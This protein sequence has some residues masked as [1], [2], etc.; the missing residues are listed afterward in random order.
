MEITWHKNICFKVKGE[1][2]TVLVGPHAEGENEAADLV[3]T[4]LAE[5]PQIEGAVNTFNWPG[6]YESKEVPVNAFQAYTSPRNEDGKSEGDDVVIFRFVVDGITVCHLGEL[7]HTLTSELVDKIGDVD[8]LMIKIGQ[9]ANLDKK[10]ALD[11]IEA[12]EPRI[13]IPMGEGDPMAALKEF[14][15]DAPNKDSKLTIKGRSSLPSDE[16]QYIVLDLK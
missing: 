6:E 13:I 2:A 4:S 12:I 11:V 14:G 5:Y 7:G 8:V 1:D 3:L 10:K 15:I 9:D 16:L